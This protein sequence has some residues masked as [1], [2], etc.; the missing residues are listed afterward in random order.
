MI[1]K[2]FQELKKSDCLLYSLGYTPFYLFVVGNRGV[3][4][5]KRIVV[6]LFEVVFLITFGID[7]L[8]KS[9]VLG[10]YRQGFSHNSQL[11][12]RAYQAVGSLFGVGNLLYFF[13]KKLIREID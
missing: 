10:E 8:Q 12:V 11:F 2:V 13:L 5:R 7:P 9:L 4:V 3:W 1:S 6:E